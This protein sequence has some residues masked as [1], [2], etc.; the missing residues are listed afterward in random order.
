MSNFLAMLLSANEIEAAS[1]SWLPLHL[2][3][4]SEKKKYFHYYINDSMIIF[5]LLSFNLWKE[6]C[7]S[8]KFVICFKISIHDILLYFRTWSC[9][10]VADLRLISQ[11]EGV[12]NFSRSKQ[13]FSPNTFSILIL[14]DVCVWGGGGGKWLVKS[15]LLFYLLIS[16]SY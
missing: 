6:K 5:L 8:Y 9:N 12:E 7:L 15:S 10:A 14:E 13:F 11:K 4:L 1:C 3:G 2:L 16:L